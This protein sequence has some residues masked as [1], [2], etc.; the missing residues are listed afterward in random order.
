MFCSRCGQSVPAGAAFCN[1]CGTPV[2]S[3][4]AQN[5]RLERTGV[6]TI[7]G[8]VHYAFGALYS[9]LALLCV[10]GVIAEKNAGGKAA[11]VFGVVV[12]GTL[13]ALELFC[14]H[15]L[16]TLRRRGRTLEIV[17]SSIGLLFFPIG[18]IINGAVL[19]YMFRPG[20]IV[21]FS[22]KRLSALT[23]YEK[24]NVYDIQQGSAGVVIAVVLL[25]FGAIAYVGILSA[26]AIPNLLTAM[27]RAKQKRT[28]ADMQTLSA[29][30]EA[31]G[32]EM[33]MYPH[34]DDLSEL[35]SSLVPKYT[36]TIF[37]KDGWGKD[38][39]YRCWSRRDTFTCD[40][41]ALVS[42][43]RDLKFDDADVL[44]A[45]PYTTT[46]FDCDIIYANGEFVAYPEGVRSAS[47]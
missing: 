20:I 28:M 14:A 13:A 9:L 34:A 2:A 41:Y 7:L 47:K 10:F 37:T 16:W 4:P 35:Q 1:S 22:E 25:F 33:H 15:G 29:A 26:I 18:T 46:N 6:I 43:G 30:I 27:E 32:Q 31:Y 38:I 3:S 19:Y 17:L 24:Q 5:V 23:P 44:N 39:R 45:K 36:N 11:A 21:L 12:L 8:V 40:Q 42:G